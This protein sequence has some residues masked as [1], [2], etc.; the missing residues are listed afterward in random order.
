MP[1]LRVHPSIVPSLLAL[2]LAFGWAWREVVLAQEAKSIVGSKTV[3]VDDVAM[4]VYKDDGKTVGKVGVYFD[5]PTELCSSLVTGRF[6]IDPGKSPHPP[7]VHP[8]EEIL[9]VESGHGSIFVDGKTTKIGPG[10]VM[11]SAPNVPHNITSDGPEPVVF[12]FMKWL[13]RP[14]E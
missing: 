7:H 12:Y 4:S 11:F 5:G 8:D 13:P 2:A 10:S 14:A 6:V 9:I 3:I 1:R